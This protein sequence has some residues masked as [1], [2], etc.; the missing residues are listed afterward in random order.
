VTGRGN[1]TVV[2]VARRARA[3]LAAACAAAITFGDATRK[4]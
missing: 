4:L 2:Q 1:G 3:Q